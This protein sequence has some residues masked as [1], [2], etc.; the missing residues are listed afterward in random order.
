MYTID[1]DS[2]VMSKNGNSSPQRH[3]PLRPRKTAQLVNR[4]QNAVTFTKESQ[5]MGL[6]DAMGHF[7]PFLTKAFRVSEGVYGSTGCK[8]VAEGEEYFAAAT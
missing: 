8:G 7:D 3:D 6:G 1:C 2:V 4:P 5:P